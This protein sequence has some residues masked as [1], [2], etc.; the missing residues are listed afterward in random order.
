[1]SDTYYEDDYTVMR[2]V[3]GAGTVFFASIGVLLSCALYSETKPGAISGI[4]CSLSLI[5]IYLYV[6]IQFPKKLV[7][8]STGVYIAKGFFQPDAFW[9]WE[10]VEYSCS[11]ESYGDRKYGTHTLNLKNTRT[12]DNF[13][14]AMDSQ[15]E[16]DRLISKLPG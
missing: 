5:G 8:D 2:L 3:A 10:D 15:S 4:V 9:P 6:F 7:I 13:G 16:L 14:V 12:G 11:F 1:M